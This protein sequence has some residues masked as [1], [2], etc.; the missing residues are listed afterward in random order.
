MAQ[1]HPLCH[2]V[3]WPEVSV[4]AERSTPGTVVRLHTAAVSDVSL[5]F[6][7]TTLP[8]TRYSAASCNRCLNAIPQAAST[9]PNP[10]RLGCSSSSC[11]HR[12]EYWLCC[13]FPALSCGRCGRDGVG[14]LVIVLNWN[15]PQWVA[16]DPVDDSILDGNVTYPIQLGVTQSNDGH[17]RGINVADVS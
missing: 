9:G 12:P 14:H 3:P 13:S 7:S 11:W 10:G 2:F 17:Y 8:G 16:I 5:E 4:S 6:H 1:G 15:V